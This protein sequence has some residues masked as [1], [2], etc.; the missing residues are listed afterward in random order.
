MEMRRFLKVQSVAAGRWAVAYIWYGTASLPAPFTASHAFVVGG[1]AM[2]QQSWPS[3][4]GLAAC[5]VR[6]MNIN[7]D[8][9][10]EVRGGWGLKQ[11]K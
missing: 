3:A 6:A 10:L 8:K 4:W 11:I 5:W 7:R 2:E 9:T 1:T